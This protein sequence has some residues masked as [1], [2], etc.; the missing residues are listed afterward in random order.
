MQKKT[1]SGPH[2]IHMEK[3]EPIIRRT[4][5]RRLADHESVVPR[6]VAAQSTASYARPS[7][8]LGSNNRSGPGP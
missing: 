7:P 1:S 8:V 4:V 5:L 2:A 6:G 3:R